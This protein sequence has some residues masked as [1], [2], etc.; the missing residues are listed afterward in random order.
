MECKDTFFNADFGVYTALKSDDNTYSIHVN[1]VSPT[2]FTFRERQ[3]P[4][5]IGGIPLISKGGVMASVSR[6]PPIR[7]DTVKKV[8][9]TLFCSVQKAHAFQK[10][11]KHSPY[12]TMTA[13]FS[14]MGV[15]WLHHSILLP[16]TFLGGVS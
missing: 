3:S 16:G 6:C 5:E 11:S 8:G 4:A 14:T 12:R 15:W 1:G 13:V 7:Q 2:L 9:T 10:W